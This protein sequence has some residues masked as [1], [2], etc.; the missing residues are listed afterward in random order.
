MKARWQELK[1]EGKL[2]QIF[3]YAEA[4]ALWLDQQQEK[5]FYLSIANILLARLVVY[6]CDSWV[7]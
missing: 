4:R 3:Q 5:N 7:V 1:T 6:P 2:E